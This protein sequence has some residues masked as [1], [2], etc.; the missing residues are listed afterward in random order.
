MANNS[1]DWLQQQ[2]EQLRREKESSAYNENFWIYISCVQQQQ[3]RR[4]RRRRRFFCG[5]LLPKNRCSL[6]GPHALTHSLT[7]GL[8]RTRVQ[9]SLRE[10]ASRQRKSSFA[11]CSPPHAHPTTHHSH[12]PPTLPPKKNNNNN[13]CMLS[14]MKQE[15]AYQQQKLRLFWIYKKASKQT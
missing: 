5:L 12:S 3:R 6:C 14:S 11:P 10:Q 9:G 15:R 1:W 2:Q 4:H 8:C 7:L 13:D